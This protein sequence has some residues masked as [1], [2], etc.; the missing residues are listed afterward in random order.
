M[1]KYKLASAVS[2]VSAISARHFH[3]AFLCLVVV[4]VVGIRQIKDDTRVWLGATAVGKLLGKVNR[5][6]EAEAAVVVDVDV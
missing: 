4:R 3:P 6:I 5:A 2:A 1:N